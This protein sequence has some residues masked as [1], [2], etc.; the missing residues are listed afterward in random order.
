MPDSVVRWLVDQRAPLP[1]HLLHLGLAPAG[2]ACSQLEP[3]MRQKE[4]A[5]GLLSSH[6]R[7]NPPVAVHSH[8]ALFLPGRAGG[9]EAPSLGDHS[10]NQKIQP[11]ACCRVIEERVNWRLFIGSLVGYCPIRGWHRGRGFST[12]R[13]TDED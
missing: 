12:S 5:T 6:G 10:F 3:S 9:R 1:Y 13:F 4:A 2:S 7:K 8:S 11:P